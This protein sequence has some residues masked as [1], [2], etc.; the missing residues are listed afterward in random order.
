MQFK[1]SYFGM[2]FFIVFGILLICYHALGVKIV[3]LRLSV[4]IAIRISS[5]IFLKFLIVLS[6]WLLK[7]M[8]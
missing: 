6:I 7:H 1:N 8:I 3:N 4:T 5:I 2:R